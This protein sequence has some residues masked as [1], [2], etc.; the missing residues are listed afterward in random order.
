MRNYRLS[1]AAI[2][3]LVLCPK[4]F[5]ALE[6]FNVAFTGDQEVPVNGSP[7]TGGGSILFDNGANTLT[8]QNIVYS[9]LTANSTAAHIHGPAAPGANASVLYPLTSFTTLG[10]TSGAFSGTLPLVAGT[11]GY[12]LAQQVSQLESGQWYINVHDA[13][14]P[15]GEIRGQIVAVPEPSTVAL[16]GL[17]ACGLA[18]V[19]RRTAT[20]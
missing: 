20:A 6:Y 12:T 14:L 19:R 1:L 7:A 8:L 18:W 2:G 11:G 5:A 3:L 9:G 13:N 15:G 4:S 10:G 17:G 16:L